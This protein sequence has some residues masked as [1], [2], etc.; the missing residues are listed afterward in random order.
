MAG[1][2]ITIQEA[3]QHSR[4]WD[5]MIGATYLGHL[6]IQDATCD[7]NHGSGE[8]QMISP[9]IPFCADGGEQVLNLLPLFQR[10]QS[11]GTRHPCNFTVLEPA[12]GLSFACWIPSDSH[13]GLVHSIRTTSKQVI[14]YYKQL[15]IGSMHSVVVLWPGTHD[16]RICFILQPPDNIIWSAVTP[17]LRQDHITFEL[18]QQQHHIQATNTL[19]VDQRS[20]PLHSGDVLQL[21]TTD[22]IRA[23][24][25]HGGPLLVLPADASFTQRAEFATNTHGWLAADE[26]HFIGQIL[27]WTVPNGPKH[28]APAYWDTEKSE[29]EESPFGAP[30]IWLNAHTILPV[31]IDNHWCSLEIHRADSAVAV[32]TFQVPAHLHCRI[33]LIL[34]RLLDYG[35]HRMLIAHSR[36]QRTPH[37]CGW[38]L[39]HR[40]VQDQA[41]LE[42]LATAEERPIPAGELHDQVALVLQASIEDW[43]E[44]GAEQPVWNLAARL[45]RHFFTV[46]ANKVLQTGVTNQRPLA[47]SFPPQRPPPARSPGQLT[48]LQR[49]CHQVQ[50]RI[51]E[52][53]RPIQS[54]RALT[55]LSLRW[56]AH[57]Q[58]SRRLSSAHPPSG[59]TPWRAC[60]T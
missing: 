48:P 58:S 35:P 10:E 30:T 15:I 52:R 31:L 46:L 2:T 51:V 26:M 18:N 29:F 55:R 49:H 7:H 19:P 5:L 1:H 9:T 50:D 12:I 22:T 21:A 3:I 20:G 43:I 16:G 28:S 53:L 32:T 27:H 56:R 23:G 24:G 4:T 11:S 17:P 37:L 6:H 54:G 41:L 60:S 33:I 39:V 34:A 42:T 14:S 47:I 25:H 44:A 57:D 13:D 59:T 40:W 8:S 38:H 36:D 45:R